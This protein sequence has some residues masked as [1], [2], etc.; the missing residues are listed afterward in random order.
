M[1]FRCITCSADLSTVDGSV[2]FKCPGCGE[3]AV[4]RCGTCRKSAKPWKCKCG[5]GGP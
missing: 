2:R 1:E 3:E 4:Y 5:F